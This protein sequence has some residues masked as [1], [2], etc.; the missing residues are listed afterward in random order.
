MNDLPIFFVLAAKH[1]VAFVLKMTS[2]ELST[3]VAIEELSAKAS[4]CEYF[5][6]TQTRLYKG[7]SIP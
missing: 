3:L 1:S 2:M 4:E 7:L 6:L 5:V